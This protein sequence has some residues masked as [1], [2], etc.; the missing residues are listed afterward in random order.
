MEKKRIQTLTTDRLTGI[1]L[2]IINGSH[3]AC[4]LVVT[5]IRA[6][7]AL[8]AFQRLT[9]C[10]R[11]IDGTTIDFRQ[12]NLTVSS[13]NELLG[14]LQ[15]SILI[16]F[17]LLALI[18]GFRPL[19]TDIDSHKEL[20][21]ALD[22]LGGIALSIIEIAVVDWDYGLA[23]SGAFQEKEILA[24]ETLSFAPVHFAVLNRLGGNLHTQ[25]GGIQEKSSPTLLALLKALGNQAIGQV[26]LDAVFVVVKGLLAHGRGVEGHNTLVI[27]L[28]LL[29]IEVLVEYQRRK[30][31]LA[32]DLGRNQAI[33]N[34]LLGHTRGLINRHRVVLLALT[35][36]GGVVVLVEQTVQNCGG[37]HLTNTVFDVESW[38]TLDAI[39]VFVVEETVG[40]FFGFW[41]G[42][43][44]L[45]EL[46]QI[47]IGG[48]IDALSLGIL[49][50]TV[51]DSD[52]LAV[53]SLHEEVPGLI[54]EQT[55]V[56]FGANQTS[57]VA[58]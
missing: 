39:E 22:A 17:V 6:R 46:V 23:R 53:E 51:F 13:R 56:V 21:F 1:Y 57:H 58:D 45:G 37:N 24:L 40:G 26:V 49:L 31:L 41:D 44:F 9:F 52:L 25:L 27:G 43:A 33:L 10:R 50:E 12:T 20:R 11:G 30:T 5:S 4:Q 15:T 14:A 3:G 28:E 55:L 34:S 48:A 54:A 18:N 42:E 2:A 35:T 29:Q 47:E 16:Q 32:L 8:V 38:L 19:H 36:L 7:F